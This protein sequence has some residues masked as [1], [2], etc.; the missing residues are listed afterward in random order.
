[1]VSIGFRASPSRVT[2]AIVR[3][4][5]ADGFQLVSTSVVNVPPALEAPRQLQFVRTALLDIMDEY[6]TTRAGLRTVEN[7]AKTKNV[8][9]MNLEGVIQELLASSTVEHFEAAAVTRMAALLGYGRD[10]KA[11]KRLIDGEA[12]PELSANWSALRADEREAVLI[13]VAAASADRSVHAGAESSTRG[14]AS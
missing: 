8:F 11:V 1:M 9:R 7:V 4:S 12:A 2:Y 5:A 3:G 10:V 13:A 14:A 6:G